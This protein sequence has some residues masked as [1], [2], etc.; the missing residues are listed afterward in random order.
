MSPKE[1]APRPAPS[2]GPER[3]RWERADA[4]L[5]ITISL[6]AGKCEARVQDVSRSGVCFF[7]DRPIALMTVLEMSLALR[8]PGGVRHVRGHGA[9]VRC[10]KISRAIE[11]YE[12]AV[13]LHEMAELDRAAIEEFVSELQSQRPAKAAA[14]K[15]K[16]AG[17]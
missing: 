17:G 11:H 14:P 2:S 9:V 1:P 12:I 16:H 4:D 6:A 8:V 3:R 5:P 7:L 10:E 13:F 15:S